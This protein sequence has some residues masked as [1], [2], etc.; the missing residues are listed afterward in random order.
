[1]VRPSIPVVFYF[2]VRV[3]LRIRDCN[4]TPYLSSVAWKGPLCPGSFMIDIIVAFRYGIIW[5]S[6]CEIRRLL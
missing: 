4:A 1:M 5:L 3:C 2:W 6:C